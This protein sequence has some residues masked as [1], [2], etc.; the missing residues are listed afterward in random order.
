MPEF[1]EEPLEPALHRKIESLFAPE[2]RAQAER[3]VRESC[4]NL[5][6]VR[7]GSRDLM[8]VRAAVL[9]LSGGRLDKLREAIAIR[10]WRDIL[11]W[12]GFGAGDAWERW[13]EE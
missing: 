13:L 6:F 2:E 8:R 10:D 1:V 7:S 4:A 12:S 3:L 11:V 9:K 5:P